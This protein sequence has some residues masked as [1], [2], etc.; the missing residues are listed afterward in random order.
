MLQRDLGD[1]IKR[2][3]GSIKTLQTMRE[4]LFRQGSA[5][6]CLKGDT[7]EVSFLNSYSAKLT[8]QL[9]HFYKSISDR[10]SK[11]LLIIGGMNVKFKLNPPLGK[12][13]KN[14]MKKVPLISGE[15]FSGAGKID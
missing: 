10:N 5:R 8:E 9:N 7:L 6:L 15:K 1:L 13:H 4:T 2:H 14:G 11:G 3:D 12:E